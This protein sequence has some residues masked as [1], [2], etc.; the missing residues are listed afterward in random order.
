MGRKRL[1][2]QF[3][4]PV[5]YSLSS[6]HSGPSVLRSSY[7]FARGKPL[8]PRPPAA[9]LGDARLSQ[10]LKGLSAREREVSP[11]PF[12]PTRRVVVRH[13]P[14]TPWQPVRLGPKRGLPSL[15][16]PRQGPLAVCPCTPSV[17]S[18]QL[19]TPSHFAD[20]FFIKSPLRPVPDAQVELGFQKRDRG[21]FCRRP[22]CEYSKR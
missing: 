8:D 12:I 17:P 22:K 1:V 7:A 3:R 9:A 15:D 21:K 6:S 11:T 4:A 16:T 20:G 5:I 10:T 2:S 18:S 13:S 14:C 19:P